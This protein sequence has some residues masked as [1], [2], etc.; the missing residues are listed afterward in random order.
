MLANVKIAFPD[1]V[2]DPTLYEVIEKLAL[3]KPNLEFIHDKDCS[4]YSNSYPMQRPP[5]YVRDENKSFATKFLVVDNGVT[6]GILWIESHYSGRSGS[7][8][9]RFGVSS[10]LISN[11]RGSRSTKYT[12]DVTKA[13]ALAKKYMS[14]KSLGRILY[15]TYSE[16]CSTAQDVMRSLVYPINRGNFLT[17]QS[18]AVILLHAFMTDQRAN[19][20]HIESA[21]RAK[22][23]TPE[24]EKALS[25]FYLAEYFRACYTQNQVRFIHR[26][27][28]G[29]A[30]FSDVV[31]QD[32]EESDKAA[33][34]V[35]EFEQLPVHIQEKIG[36]LQL[37]Q[38]KELV[39][40]VGLR[41]DEST[42]F[43]M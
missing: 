10:H 23:E 32:Q 8:R 17:S 29:Y 7:K 35:L 5:N 25:E 6:A 13:V 22:I 20:S 19:V 37:L 43:V 30:F 15:E 21:L 4:Y 1:R 11:S 38:D 24:F 12:S 26:H 40:D 3:L 28:A 2:P 33:V 18:D 34:T 42:F 14:A 36:V 39:K 16:A 9:W 41:V 31:P 27:D